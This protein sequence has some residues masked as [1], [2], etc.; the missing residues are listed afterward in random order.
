LTH[1]REAVVFNRP[2]VT[3]DLRERHTELLNKRATI[4]DTPG[5]FDAFSL[6][7]HLDLMRFV[8]SEIGRVIGE[9]SLIIL[10]LDGTSPGITPSDHEI[11]QL[12]RKSGKPVIVA[13]NKADRRDAAA[14]YSEA[15]ELGF[16]RV[17]KISAEHGDGIDLLLES[18]CDF[19]PDEELQ[20]HTD[21]SEQAMRLA[22]IGRPNTGKSAIVNSIIGECKRLVGDFVGLTRESAELEFRFKG[23]LIKI[24]DTP[25]LRR[26][27]KI[28]DT[29]EMIVDSNGRNAYRNADA[30]ILVIDASSL[31]CGEVES[32]DLKIAADIVKE[33]KALI[34]AFNKC[35]I[36]PFK[37]HDTPAFLQRNFRTSF[38]QLK[39]VPFL[40]VS[41]LLRIN[42]NK[43]LKLTLLAYDK[44]SRTVKTSDLNS[45]LR[46]MCQGG[47]LQSCA[48]RFSLKYITQVGTSPPTFLIFIS[49]KSNIQES[50]RRFIA[51][52]LRSH[53]GLKDVPI[54]IILRN[55]REPGNR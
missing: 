35:D 27:S 25:G 17:I 51:N 36:T 16:E 29:L 37:P 48:A 34:I 5:L 39:E 14:V 11:T 42:I 26:K 1:G 18:I 8:R 47:G 3:R 22:I 33:G 7:G 44:Y 19:I 54:R 10:V 23:R 30:V 53:F 24:I 2:G 13:I 49:N 52:N 41:A 15:T 45:W 12:V 9:S 28:T 31:I 38:A 6:G 50:Q 32:Y 40:L 4:V 46:S 43:M 21:V 20:K 55:R